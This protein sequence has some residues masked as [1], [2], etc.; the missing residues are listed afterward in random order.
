MPIDNTAHIDVVPVQMLHERLGVHDPIE[1]PAESQCKPFSKWK[2]EVD[3]APILRYIYRNFRP[4]RHLEFGTWEGTGACYCL[5]ECNATVWTINLPGGEVADDRPAYSSSAPGSRPE[6]STVSGPQ[7]GTVRYQ[8]DAGAFIGHRYR[9]AG[10]GH[11]VC[12][13]YCDSREWDTS[14]YPLPFFDTVLIDGGHT[15]DV[16]ISDTRKALPLVRPGGLILWHDFCPDPAVFGLFSSVPG[17]VRGLADHWP[18]IVTSLQ[19]AFWIR[20]SFLLVGIR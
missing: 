9:E 19:A 3:D 13:I 18:E 15:S 5:E 8:T 14:G 1:Y 6:E 2:M 7:P 20:P 12:Q 11:R 16:V 4:Q 17:V 10:F